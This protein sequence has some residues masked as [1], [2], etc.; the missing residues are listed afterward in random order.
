MQK[1]GEMLIAA[2]ATK[3]IGKNHSWWKSEKCIFYIIIVHWVNQEE[4]K[5]PKDE[6]P[7]DKDFCESQESPACHD[8]RGWGRNGNK[9]P[10]LAI[11]SHVKC[12]L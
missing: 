7:K 10:N 8:R 2:A 12:V 1:V 11:F 6:D 4:L 9:A 3:A 5:I